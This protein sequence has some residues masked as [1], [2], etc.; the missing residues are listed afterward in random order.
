MNSFSA[1]LTRKQEN[2]GQKEPTRSPSMPQF[3]HP[4]TGGNNEPTI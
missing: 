1:T 2:C 3:H 4:D